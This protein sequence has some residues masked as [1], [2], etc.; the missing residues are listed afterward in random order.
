MHIRY[1]QK[2]KHSTPVFHYPETWLISLNGNP[3]KRRISFACF[4]SALRAS[5]WGSNHASIQV[6]FETAESRA[7]FPS[8]RHSA[9]NFP[10]ERWWKRASLCSVHPIAY[11]RDHM[12]VF[13]FFTTSAL[14]IRFSPLSGSQLIFS[15]LRKQHLERSAEVTCSHGESKMQ[16]NKR[17]CNIGTDLGSVQIWLCVSFMPSKDRMPGLFRR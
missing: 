1:V 4:L 6:Q 8:H 5:C 14:T 15:E 3:F 17:L 10:A 9:Q 7:T 11:V 12:Y 13:A 2:N 16:E